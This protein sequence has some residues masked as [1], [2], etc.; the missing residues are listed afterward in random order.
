MLTVHEYCNSSWGPLST[1]MG[2]AGIVSTTLLW[3]MTDMHASIT[4]RLVF[5]WHMRNT[6]HDCSVQ[7]SYTGNTG[8]VTKVKYEHTISQTWN[9]LWCF[10]NLSLN[11][12]IFIYFLT[13]PVVTANVWHYNFRQCSSSISMQKCKSLIY[14]YNNKNSNSN[15]FNTC[16][17]RVFGCWSPG[18]VVSPA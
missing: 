13:I 8:L 11:F 14:A 3:S 9:S 15:N 17:T 18:S 2:V 16:C 1:T 7:T 6:L 4:A 5:A 10:D 12:A